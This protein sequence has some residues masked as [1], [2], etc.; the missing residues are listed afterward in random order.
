MTEILA[1]DR[2]DVLDREAEFWTTSVRE[3]GFRRI[4]PWI[5][6]A[7]GPYSREFE[8]HDLYDP[9]G[10]DVLDYGCGVGTLSLELLARGARH[11]TGFDIADGQVAEA[12]QRAEAAGVSDRVDF[13]VDDAHATTFPDDSFDLVVGVAILHHLDLEV[14]LREIRRVL[15]P[16]GRAVF[17]EPLWHNPLL[18]LGRRLTPSARTPD[19]HPL[20]E[21]DWELCHS[22]FP[23]FEHVEREFLTIPLMPANLVLPSGAQERLAEH[24][25]R[26]DRW[27]LERYPSTRKYARITLLILK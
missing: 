7:I 6:R 8:M 18:R 3:G 24:V 22:I 9:A 13:L 4:R 27:V 23:D 15:R 11:V 21:Q 2:R 25:T 17:L 19:E 20:T 12:T 16:G 26:A 5:N 10:K 1:N 14:A